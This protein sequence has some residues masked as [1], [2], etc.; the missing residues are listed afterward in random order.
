VATN[1]RREDDEAPAGASLPSRI[2]AA[3]F[4]RVYRE[5]APIVLRA[6][7]RLVP[8]SSVHDAAQDVF[9]VVARRL[10][11]FEDR[12][13]ASTWVYGIVLRVA[14][15]YRR[16]QRRGERRQLALAAEP[17]P[18]SKNPEQR[19]EHASSVRLLHRVLGAMTDELR[20]VFVLAE[21]EQLPGPAIAAL[22][23]LNSNTMHSRLRAA[24]GEFNVL[25]RRERA[26]G[27]L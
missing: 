11:D 25:V 16:A 19:A 2:D 1:P 23:G 8:Q 22:L 5:T 20:E 10:D 3:R 4:E 24:R 15:D 27:S 21:L 7:R 17:P 9:L 6:L 12:S 14:A 26:R 18:S 13:K